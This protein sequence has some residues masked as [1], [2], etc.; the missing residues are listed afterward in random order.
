MLEGK[1]GESFRELARN[2]A[3]GAGLDCEEEI[4]EEP[5]GKLYLRGCRRGNLWEVLFSAS[6]S[7][8]RG[9][10]ESS[11][12]EV[13]LEEG[14]IRLVSFEDAVRFWQAWFRKGP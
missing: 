12:G 9:Y 5:G 7:I 2:V 6:A 13:I 3:R 10:Y 11:E 14:K 8:R 1:L 4:L